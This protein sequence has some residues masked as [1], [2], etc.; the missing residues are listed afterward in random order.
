MLMLMNHLRTDVPEPVAGVLAKPKKT[1]TGTA[2]LRGG[3]FT[4]GV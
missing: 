4:R 1:M 3:S 2:D